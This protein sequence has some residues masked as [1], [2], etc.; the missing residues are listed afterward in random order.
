MRCIET[1]QEGNE[2]IIE[3]VK[4]QHEMYWNVLLTLVLLGFDF[5]KQQHEMYWN[6]TRMCIVGEGPD[7]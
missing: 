3:D 7:S 4:Q 6:L 1:K 5:V 2:D